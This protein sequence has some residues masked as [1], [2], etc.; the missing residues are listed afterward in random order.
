LI[1]NAFDKIDSYISTT[2]LLGQIK[3][4]LLLYKEAKELMDKGIIIEEIKD[5]KIINDILRISNSIPNDDF[6]KIE[7]IKKRLLEEINSLKT[8]FHSLR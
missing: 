8:T 6:I 5:L 7:E 3:I 2:K 1:Q 4:I